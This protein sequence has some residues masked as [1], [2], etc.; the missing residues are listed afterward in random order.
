MSLLAFG[1]YNLQLFWMYLC[2]YVRETGFY[3]LYCENCTWGY[4][5]NLL[6]NG[7]EACLNEFIM[8]LEDYGCANIIG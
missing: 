1:V 6:L 8:V 2:E 3:T 7:T 5:M 4:M